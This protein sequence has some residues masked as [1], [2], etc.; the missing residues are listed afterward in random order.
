MKI[1]SDERKLKPTRVDS[2]YYDRIPEEDDEDEQSDKD[3]KLP[4]FSKINLFDGKNKKTDQLIQ[5]QKSTIRNKTLKY[6]GLSSKKARKNIKIIKDEEEVGLFYLLSI[7]LFSSEQEVRDAIEEKLSLLQKLKDICLKDP[8]KEQDLKLKGNGVEYIEKKMSQAIYT[9]QNYETK[10]K[11][12]NLLKVRAFVHQA[13]T[14]KEVERIRNKRVHLWNIFKIFVNYTEISVLE[15]DINMGFFAITDKRTSKVIKVTRSQFRG[16]HKGFE[17]NSFFQNYEHNSGKEVIDQVSCLHDL[18]QGLL[19]EVF[20]LFAVFEENFEAPQKTFN[21]GFYEE[22]LLLDEHHGIYP[23]IDDRIC[24][25]YV[26]MTVEVTNLNLK[27][28]KFLAVGGASIIEAADENFEKITDVMVFYGSNP[29]L[30]YYH[31]SIFIKDK[32]EEI[33]YKFKSAKRSS[34]FYYLLLDIKKNLDKAS[35]PRIQLTAPLVTDGK[36]YFTDPI[37]GILLNDNEVCAV[38]DDK[39]KFKSNLTK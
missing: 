39:F 37:Y 6:K 31:D 18:Q 16:F 9:A 5:E 12:F 33:K 34:E 2:L 8:G 3:S 21:S 17:I 30:T 20:N 11:Y 25:K 36:E 35:R 38:Y 1:E 28:Q 29:E 23:I 7:T 22:N 32:E 27:K 13:I 24:P 10:K 19:H 4:E 15:F 14:L 26:Y